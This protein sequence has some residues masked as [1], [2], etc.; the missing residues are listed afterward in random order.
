MFIILFVLD[1]V[2]LIVIFSNMLLV[3]KV[4]Y[5]LIFIFDCIYLDVFGFLWLGVVVRLI[6]LLFE[7]KMFSFFLCLVKMLE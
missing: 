1:W 5:F 3:F 7:G 2:M 4:K 6:F